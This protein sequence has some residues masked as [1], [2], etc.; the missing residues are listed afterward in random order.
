MTSLNIKNI[1]NDQMVIYPLGAGQEVGRSCIILEYKGKT[2]MFDCG[3]HMG[4]NGHASLPYFDNIKPDQIDIIFI[5]H[6][7]LDHCAALPYFIAK[8]DFDGKKQKVYATS[9]TRAIY[10][11]VLR[12]SLTDK[13]ENIKLYTADDI[14][15]SMEV[16]NVIDFYE[17]MEHENIKFK[18]YP[19]GHVLGAAMFL[20]EIDGVRVLYTGDYSTE[21]DILIPPAQIPNEK[22]DV[23]IVEGTYGKCNHESRSEREQQ[24]TQEVMRIVKNKGQCLLPVFAL[25]RAQE[26]VLILEEFWKQNSSELADIKIHFTQ[27]LSKKANQIFQYY[28]SMMADPIRKNQLN[29]FNLHYAPN[30]ITK[31][32]EIDENKPC[33][34]L[35]SPFN[36]QSGISRTIIER[37]CSKPQNGVILTGFCPENTLS[38]E[39]QNEK[40]DKTINSIIDG[41]KIPF[42]M[43]VKNISFSAH[44]DLNQTTNFIR[45]IE[46]QHVILVHGSSIKIKELQKELMKTFVGLQVH[47]PNN[48]QKICFNLNATESC[49]IV[50]ELEKQISQ[51]ILQYVQEIESLKQQQAIANEDKEIM[52]EG[53]P[54]EENAHDHEMEI[55]EKD[56]VHQHSSKIDEEIDNGEEQ[57]AKNIESTTEENLLIKKQQSFKNYPSKSFQIE[58]VMIADENDVLMMN[59]QDVAKYKAIKQVKVFTSMKFHYAGSLKLVQLF[60][61]QIFYKGEILQDQNGVEYLKIFDDILIYVDQANQQAMIKWIST[62]RND[63]I[64]DIFGD[65]LSQIK[66]SREDIFSEQFTD[67]NNILKEVLREYPDSLVRLEE[68]L[69]IINKD[70]VQIGT[71]DL[72]EK[73]I[74]TGQKNKD[75]EEKY[76]SLLNLLKKN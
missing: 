76:Q 16:I 47:A 50:G 26:I 45:A 32:D 9:P 18:C 19:A 35:S 11:H 48:Q 27:N 38:K 52:E 23:L 14:E 61:N 55:E 41:R 20:V 42:N 28:K 51:Y 30:N 22:V 65:Y 3:L 63:I 17:E 31:H 24:L 46:P 40:Q 2:I 6:F 58:G 12:D 60:S 59:S 74:K 1:K 13:S 64:A 72:E 71:I 29:P 75:I 56:E 5:T 53:S 15:K 62:E 25:G 4:K 66:D 69:I 34:I 49:K 8:T 7:H 36:L 57:N 67:G 21:K 54:K 39:I 73:E 43:S 44:A 68:G 37:I 70:N 10:R 33:V